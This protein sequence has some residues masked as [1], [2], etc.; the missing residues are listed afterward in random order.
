[1]TKAKGNRINKGSRV[2]SIAS[3]KAGIVLK[4]WP[5]GNLKVQWL[6][7]GRFGMVIPDDPEKGDEGW[8]VKKDAVRLQ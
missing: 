5:S 1:M 2:I 4:V 3:G 7:N 8:S 6:F